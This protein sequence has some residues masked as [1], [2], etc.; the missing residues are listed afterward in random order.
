MFREFLQW[1]KFEKRFSEHTVKSYLTDLEKFNDFLKENYDGITVEQATT[2]IIKSWI[3]D[4]MDHEYN[5]VSVSR[6]IVSLNAYYKFLIKEGKKTD[7]PAKEIKGPKKPDRLVKYL[8]ENEIKKVLDEI[9]YS[10]DFQGIRDRLILEMLYGTGIRLSEIIGLKTQNVDLKLSLIKVLGKRNKERIIPMNST[11][12]ELVNSYLMVKNL[13]NFEQAAGEYL[14]L[15]DK[16]KKL[17][18][19]FVYRVV[20]KYIELFVIRTKISPH[21]LRHSF[22]THLLNRGADLNAI[23]ELLGHANLAATQIYTHNTIEKLKKV[24]KQTHPRG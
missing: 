12:K 15:T 8:E 20:K 9:D 22:A 24:Y 7:N 5:P 10:H 21:V 4:L 18:P 3:V 23:K 11:L 17:Y 19:M 14:I 16:G 2:P 6:K 1:L 13:E